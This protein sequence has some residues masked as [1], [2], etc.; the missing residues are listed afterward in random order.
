MAMFS[1]PAARWLNSMKLA[2]LGLASVALG[3]TA[4]PAEA[5]TMQ[6][7]AYRATHRALGDL[8][9]FQS[10]GR[11]TGA[12]SDQ[13]FSASGVYMGDQWV[14]TAAHVVDDANRMSF[15]L[16]GRSYQASGWAHHEDW[17]ANQLLGGH[18]IAM[19]RLSDPV[20][21]VE[22]ASL[23]EGNREWGQVGY[24]V[25]YGLTGDGATGYDRYSSTGVRRAGTNVIDAVAGRDESVLLSDFDSGSGR[26]NALG[27]ADPTAYEY[28]IAPGDSGGGLFVLEDGQ[29]QLAGLHSFGWGAL[30]GVSDASFGDIS[31]HTRVSNFVP[32][33]DRLMSL[34]G[35]PLASAGSDLSPLAGDYIINGE[36]TS[37]G[38]PE[39]ATATMLL[40]AAGACLGRR[41]RR[42]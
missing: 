15:D 24:S 29:V 32:W 20:D 41:R 35:Q 6:S 22:A 39:P 36:L 33:I 2:G 28:V 34:D 23:Y 17:N 3:L 30:D 19:V 13:G 21:G 12:G 4:L 5:G 9:P 7:P 14:L 26:D 37:L 10:V 27:S 11:M 16:G 1:Q 8:A 25:G 40:L 42:A 38:I 18:D 31:G